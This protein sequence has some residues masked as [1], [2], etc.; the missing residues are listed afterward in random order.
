M[1]DESLSDEIQKDAIQ[2]KEQ[3]LVFSILPRD[4]RY[5]I[6]YY[7]L[8]GQTIVIRS[9]GE[10]NRNFGVLWDQAKSTDKVSMNYPTKRFG[11]LQ[12]CRKIAIRSLDV[13]VNIHDLGSFWEY[14]GDRY[15]NFKE[16]KDLGPGKI[17]EVIGTMK[18]LRKL[19]VRF[20]YDFTQYWDRVAPEIPPE[21]VVK[22]EKDTL[23][24]LMDFDW[25]PDFEVEVSWLA[26]ED[27]ESTLK[28]APFKLT[29]KLQNGTSG[30][31]DLSINYLYD[32][33]IPK[34]LR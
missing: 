30:T 15:M 6:Y 7:V 9:T 5:R 10:G 28:G 4:V 20:Q 23:K 1:S 16:G 12:T 13:L 29:R 32:R 21:M 33:M 11:I 14:H 31:Y 27:S 22:T 25:I 34:A 26:D 18:G 3:C 17:W 8:G 19:R 2:N 24:P